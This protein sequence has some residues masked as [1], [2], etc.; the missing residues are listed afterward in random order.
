MR[1]QDQVIKVT[2][3]AVA[4]LV[5][6]VE[7]LPTDRLDWSPG[8][9]RSAVDQLRE[10]AAV[11]EALIG[12]LEGDAR[13]MEGHAERM[14]A[15]AKGPAN[16]AELSETVLTETARLCAVIASFPDSRLEEEVTLP[17]GGGTTWTRADLLMHHYWNA[18]YHL[19]Q[20]N[21]I[22]TILGDQEMH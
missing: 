13:T 12:L 6:A 1:F 7:S 9:A 22:Q 21:Y 18:T 3:K 20:V 11:P 16:L 15:Q 19:G 8:G 14:R 10:V 2:Q 5:R 4:D 17:M